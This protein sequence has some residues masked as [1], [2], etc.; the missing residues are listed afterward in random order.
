MDLEAQNTKG[1]APVPPQL[2]KELQDAQALRRRV[3]SAL[4]QLTQNKKQKRVNQTDQDAQLMKGRQGIMPAYNAQAMVSPLVSG[5][6][7]IITA[8]DVVN[9]AS[10]TGQL[11]PM[12]EQAE[13]IVGHRVELT[14]ADGGYHTAANLAAGERRGQRLVLTERYHE[15]VQGPYF[16]DR[17][18]YQATTNSYIC[19]HGQRLSFR[20]TRPEQR[21]HP[22]P[23]SALPSLQNSMPCLPGLRGLHQ[24]PTYRAKPVDWTHR[25]LVA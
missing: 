2:P 16:K 21:Q 15:G 1:D 7:M 6:G 13:E 23:L 24:R 3:Q 11:V 19:P 4:N 12:L 9:T 22:W 10:D 18:T 17:F 20:G 8:A 14:L 25:C 5:K